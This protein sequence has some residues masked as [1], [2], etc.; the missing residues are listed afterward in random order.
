MSSGRPS[1]TFFS[2]IHT[3]LPEDNLE[4]EGRPETPETPWRSSTSRQSSLNE[5]DEMMKKSQ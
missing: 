3:P 5:L 4:G 2:R 1:A